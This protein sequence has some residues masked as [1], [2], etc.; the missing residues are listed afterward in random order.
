MNI[1]TLGSNRQSQGMILI[2]SENGR[3]RLCNDNRWRDFAMF[4]NVK[5]CVKQYRSM[6]HAKRRAKRV[7]GFV[8]LIPNGFEV[9]ASGNVIETIP[10]IDKPGYVNYKHHK[11][12]EYTVEL[13]AL[14]S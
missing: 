1:Q 4:G 7:H 3:Y 9:D 14:I 6:G 2:I 11:L 5:G 8:V 13:P 12:T 10:C